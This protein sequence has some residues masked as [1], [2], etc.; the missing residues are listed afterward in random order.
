M[1]KIKPGK[2]KRK[3]EGNNKPLATSITPTDALFF[4]AL[5]DEYNLT[6]SELLRQIVEQYVDFEKTQKKGSVCDICNGYF[7][8]IDE[9]ELIFQ[10]GACYD[11]NAAGVEEMK[12]ENKGGKQ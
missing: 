2:E 7:K 9:Q 12:N 1:F 4:D 3:S 6:K 5:A 11:C 10:T 8:D